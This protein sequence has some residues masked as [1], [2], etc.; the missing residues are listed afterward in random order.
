MKAGW[1][2]SN[3]NYLFCLQTLWQKQT[4]NSGKTVRS[5]IRKSVIQ[6]AKLFFLPDVSNDKVQAEDCKVSGHEQTLTQ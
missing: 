4:E 6:A 2:K 1:K 3:K 5:R